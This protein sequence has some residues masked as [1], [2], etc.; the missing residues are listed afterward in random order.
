MLWVLSR[1]F[2]ISISRENTLWIFSWKERFLQCK[3]GKIVLPCLSTERDS[4]IHVSVK[5]N[6]SRFSAVS[7]IS[8]HDFIMWNLLEFFSLSVIQRFL[9]A[10]KRKN[11]LRCLKKRFLH[12]EAKIILGTVFPSSPLPYFE[13]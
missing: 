8:Q 6:C 2:Y 13:C 1:D 11:I 12:Q 3:N 10:D 5:I 9:H 4:Y 7:R